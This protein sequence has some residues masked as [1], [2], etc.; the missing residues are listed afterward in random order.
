MFL[1]PSMEVRAQ[2]YRLAV[3]GDLGEPPHDL[4]DDGIVAVLHEQRQRRGAL[5]VGREPTHEGVAPSADPHLL[6]IPRALV[7]LA[8]LNC[9]GAHATVTVLFTDT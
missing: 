4:A 8:A 6:T 1:M 9:I 2:Q 3:E 5:K 7:A